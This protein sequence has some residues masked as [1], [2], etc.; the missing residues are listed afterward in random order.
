MH[1]KSLPPYP[2]II[3]LIFLYVIDGDYEVKRALYAGSKELRSAFC[4]LYHKLSPHFNNTSECLLTV[5]ESAL[6]ECDFKCSPDLYSELE[7]LTKRAKD[8]SEVAYKIFARLHTK[9]YIT[10][11]HPAVLKVMITRCIPDSEK[12]Q[13]LLADY[14]EKRK[15]YLLQRISDDPSFKNFPINIPECTSK[16]LYIRTDDTWN[17]NTSLSV[18][19][20]LET[21]F[22][23][24]IGEPIRIMLVCPGGSLILCFEVEMNSSLIFD[25]QDNIILKLLNVG[26]SFLKQQWTKDIQKTCKHYYGY[27]CYNL[28][29]NV[30]HGITCM[31][32]SLETQDT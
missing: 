6:I 32:K 4:D 16:E 3:K 13:Q 25:F 17:E 9:L 7:E 22:T 31:N 2:I 20:D 8:N 11:Q 21:I 1:E 27:R 19:Y 29:S 30:W 26:V 18:V 10:P 24:M 12:A 15:N 5:M 28:C 23:R 14:E